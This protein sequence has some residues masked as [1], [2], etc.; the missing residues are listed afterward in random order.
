MARRILFLTFLVVQLFFAQQSHSQNPANRTSVHL[1]IDG[2]KKFQQMDGF[3]ININTSWWYKGEYGDTRLVQPAIDLLLDSLGVTIFR[4]V[5]EEM[6]WE[7]VNDDNDPNNFNWT[8]F[9]NV[10]SNARFQGVWNTLRYLNQ[11]G[12][13]DGMIISLM[14][15]P[16]AAVPLAAPDQQKSWMGGTDYS[17]S[18]S[19]EDEFVESMAALLYYA[20][21]TAKVQFTLVSPFNETEQVSEARSADHPD[22]VVEGPNIPDAV[23]V[24]RVIRKLAKKLDAIGMNDIRFVTPDAAGD[25]LFASCLDEMIK[26]PY[27]MNKIAHWGVHQY[28]HTAERNRKIVSNPANPNKS[29]W[30]TET[31]GIGNILGQLGDSAQSYIF[32]D[33]FDCVYQHA[34]RNGYGDSPPNDWVFWQPDDGK[35]LLEYLPSTKSWTPRKQFYE[36]AQLFKFVRPGAIR[37]GSTVNDSSLVIRS[38]LNPDGQLVIVGCNS[39]KDT[40]TLIGTL[41]N[42]P[43][44]TSMKMV[45]TSPDMNFHKGVDIFLKNNILKGGIPPK[46]IFTLTGFSDSDQTEISNPK[47]EPAKWYAGD[48][49]VHRNCGIDRPILPEQEFTAMMKPENLAVI[50]VL[51]DMGN[52]EVQDSHLDLPKVN[53]NDAAQSEPGRLVHWDAE[54]HFDPEGVTFEHKALGGHLVLLGLHEAHQIWNESPYKILQWGK[55]QNA[56]M[57]FC[58]M[59]YLNDSIPNVLTCCIPLDYAVE[60]ALGTIDFLAEDVWLNDAA[61]HGYYRLLNCGFRPGWAAGTDYPCNDSRPLGSLLTYAEVRDQ[62]L[63][64]RGWIDAIKHGRT[65]VT[66]N[67]HVEFLD[68]KVNGKATPGDEL[69]AKTKVTL[70]VEVTWTSIRELSGRIELVCNGK[71]VAT[72]EGTARPREPVILKTSVTCSESSWL[73]A[74]RMDGNGH[75][76][77]TAPVYITIDHAPVRASAEDA[78]YFV[79]WIDNLIAKTSPGGPWNGYF[80]HDLNGVQD[81]YRKA[82]IIYQNIAREAMKIQH[83]SVMSGCNRHPSAVP[84]LILATDEGFG[85]YTG[86]ILKTEG[87]NEF[88]LDSLNGPRVN[89]S[90]LR[91]F[92]VIILSSAQVDRTAKK[93]LFDFVENG[94]NLIAFSPDQDLDGLFGIYHADGEINEGYIS[95]DT[96]AGQCKGL[97]PA[98]MRIHGTAGVYTL[99]SGRSL[100]ALYE[101][102]SSAMGYP[103]IVSNSYGKGRTVAFLYNLPENIVYTRQGNPLFAGIEKDGIPGLRGMDLFAG[104]WVDTSNNT[105]NQAD[106][107]M[108]MLSHCIE[109]MSGNT[110]PIPRFWYFPDTVKCLV[111]LTNDGEYSGEKDFEPQFRDVDSMGAK[112]SLYILVAD[113]VSKEWTE[114]WTAKGFEIAGHPDDTREAGNPAWN[115]MDSALRT[116]REEISRKF[117]LPMR[118]NVNHWFVWCGTDSAGNRDFAAEA[119]L[120]ERNG[121]ELDANYAHY[122]MLSNQGENFLGS[123]GTYHGNY[124]GSGLVMKYAG[125]SGKTINVYQHFN[126]VYD[127]EYKEM[128]DPEGFFNCFKGLADRSLSGNAFSFI[129][130]KSH[131]DEYSFSRVPLMQMLSYANQR[132]IPVWTELNLL[133]F[134]KMKD[135]ANFTNVKWSGNRLTFLLSS[136]L[137]HSAGLTVIL[138]SFWQNMRLKHILV[139][140]HDKPIILKKIRGY[141]YALITVKPGTFYHFSADYR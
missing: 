98:R 27:I 124:T 139:D 19:M 120:E 103:G 71:V 81:R 73:C 107:Q 67:G 118:T 4:A 104:G 6:D 85:T 63:T 128:H 136:Q 93:M 54:W 22:G 78:Q 74:R 108:A 140:D 99:N 23:Q 68:L 116:R 29:F 56:V 117:E 33:G 132:K 48:M 9:N 121:I 28:G 70:P 20:R 45:Y 138:P 82:R 141:E 40:M 15:G 30:V 137:T 11:K 113:K 53:G 127:Q 106:V 38:F 129:S 35:P 131:N 122:D 115:R 119:R 80:T 46:S 16:P 42:F 123:P 62:P 97:T 41:D 52:A 36:F 112:M 110:C 105:L 101:G 43:P 7:A 79:R 59:E 50:S 25:H 109:Q 89:A 100:A 87:F 44:I 88:V 18:P 55:A 72:L 96:T 64:Y 34:R 125:A 60:T 65:V 76:S 1:Q 21:N 39:G 91:K 84:I 2:T 37:I 17:I 69:Q 32:W 24:T 77:H 92:D 61:V 31:A 83:L 114:R 58:H 10:F 3:G 14:G 49:H 86:Q 130:I 133:E 26:D 66:T 57:G 12:I 47:P 51:A 5:I 90:Y 135:E 111:T 94:G 13:K 75:Q 126:S 134:L 102:R 95:L 8:Y